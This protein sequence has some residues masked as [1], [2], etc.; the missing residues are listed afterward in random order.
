MDQSD[1]VKDYS[2]CPFVEDGGVV[3]DMTKRPNI[4]PKYS[5][6]YEDILAF[7]VFDQKKSGESQKVQFLY[8]PRELFCYVF[9]QAD[10]STASWNYFCRISSTSTSDFTFTIFVSYNFI[11]ALRVFRI[12]KITFR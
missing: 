7:I 6:I 4:N 5:N 12:I 10:T 9:N 3:I 8:E 1:L 11:L 2:N